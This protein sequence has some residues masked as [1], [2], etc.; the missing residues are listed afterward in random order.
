MNVDELRRL[1]AGPMEDERSEVGWQ[2]LRLATDGEPP[3]VL[4]KC[5][6]VLRAALKVADETPG[7]SDAQWAAILPAWFMA[8]FE[9]DQSRWNS[10]EWAGWVQWLSP[11]MREWRWWDAYVTGDRT[12][13]VLIE[14]PGWPS[15]LG[16]VE[17]LLLR[18]GATS[19]KEL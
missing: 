12:A 4:E 5:R 3:A 18:C 6:E 16:A 11:D 14:T 17:N 13:D 1:D 15:P 10:W 8:T 9:G 2:T 19:V 7:P